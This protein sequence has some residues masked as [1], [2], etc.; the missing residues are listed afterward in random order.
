MKNL[1]KG[2]S[3][4]YNRMVIILIPCMI[5][6]GSVGWLVASSSG[7]QWLAS[8]VERQSGGKVSANGISG[9]LIDSFGLQRLVILGEGWRITIQDI[10]VKWEPA[11]LLSGQL[12]LLQLSARQ[13]EVLSLSSDKTFVL[14]ENLNLPLERAADESC[15]SANPFQRRCRTRFSG[16]RY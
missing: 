5:L 9:S 8:T 10:Q 12:K 4:R 3:R 2:K 14:P 1:I 7:L 15:L 16:E 6:A 13:I 11:A